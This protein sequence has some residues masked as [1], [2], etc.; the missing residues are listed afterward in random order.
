MRGKKIKSPE[1]LRALCDAMALAP[2]S[3]LARVAK[4]HKISPAAVFAWQRES[5]QHEKEGREDS[6]YIFDWIGIRTYLHRHI[7]FC[8]AIAVAR[9]DSK[10]V[11]DAVTSRFEP[12]VN[13]QTGQPFWIVDPKIASDAKLL[14]DR[15]WTM[16]YGE[17]RQRSDVYTRGP[18]GALQP[19]LKEIPPAPAVLIKAASS[20]LSQTYGD[21]ISHQVQIGGVLRIGPTAP[22]PTQLK[23]LS[24]PVDVSFT[25]IDDQTEDVQPTNTLAVAERPKSVHEYEE[26]FGGRRLVEVVFFYDSDNRLLPPLEG[27]IIV[28]GSEA[29]RKY[30]EAG[31]ECK[32]TPAKEL[33]EKGF[34]N[35][36]LLKLAKPQESALVKDLRA[37]LAQGVKHPQPSHPVQKFNSEPPAT[38]LPPNHR[39][40]E[41]PP[42]SKPR[43]PAPPSDVNR[44][45]AAEQV[46]YGKPPAGGASVSSGR[47]IIH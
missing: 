39:M 14:D 41:V 26:T 43:Q 1:T 33:L 27:I 32:T 35:G 7:A 4:E 36:F 25:A 24:A 19:M 45:D 46:G 13:P 2:F 34:C 20:L 12:M 23:Q 10:I 6:E 9:I 37:K 30:S 5:V 8:R 11:E 18:D 22:S 47:S 42:L 29:H 16:I 21:K 31:I 44:I 3:G 38:K 17:N 40:Y 28:E 15:D